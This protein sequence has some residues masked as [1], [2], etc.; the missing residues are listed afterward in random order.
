MRTNEVLTE[1]DGVLL[2]Q[3]IEMLEELS[4]SQRD[5]GNDSEAEGAACSAHAVQRLA[6]ALAAAPAAE[7]VAWVRRHPDGTL[8]AELVADAAIEPIR[9]NSGAWVPLYAA[10]SQDTAPARAGPMTCPECTRPLFTR[11]DGTINCSHCSWWAPNDATPPAPQAAPVQAQGVDDLAE[12]TAR[13]DAAYEERNRVVAALAG[14]YPSGIARTAIEGW[15]EDWHGCVYIDL[16]TGQASWHYH[17]SQAYLFAHLPPYAGTWDG[18][19]TPEK[20]ERLAAAATQPPQPAEQAPGADDATVSFVAR[21]G[22]Q[23]RDCADENGV[24]PRSGLPCAGADKAIRHVLK[25]LE[26]GRQHGYLP[27]A[28]P[29][30]TP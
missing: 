30:D 17:D 18:H 3:A 14:V 20:Y 10:P 19:T 21:Y 1:Q 12:M 2:N 9:K 22:G 26:Y 4:T 13:K 28:T 5:K 7:P 15:S 25:A 8:T 23:C 27:A 16:P 11:N 24:C 6:A 29:G